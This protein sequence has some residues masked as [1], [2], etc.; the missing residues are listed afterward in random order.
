VAMTLTDEHKAS[1]VIFAIEKY[2][3]FSEH[4]LSYTRI[5]QVKHQNTTMKK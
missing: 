5:Y 4:F 2:V 3:G 1:D